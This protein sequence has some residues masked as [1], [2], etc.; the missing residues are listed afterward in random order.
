MPPIYDL[1]LE[2]VEYII[3][4]AYPSAP[5]TREAR[6]KRNE[7]LLAVALVCRTWTPFTQQSLWLDVYLESD[8]ILRFD[9][10]GPG[11]YPVQRLDLE[12][13]RADT[14]SV[15]S[16]LRN[17]RGVHELLFDLGEFNLDWLCGVSFEGRLDCP[18][19]SL[20]S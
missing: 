9:A 3:N 10:A 13:Y 11:R 7:F 19:A 1:P 12:T 4:S 16:V 5:P 8:S 6:C 20:S 17:V 14:A 18:T 15:E 2:T